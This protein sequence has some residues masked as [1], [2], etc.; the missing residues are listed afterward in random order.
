MRVTA[1][2]HAG[3]RVETEQATVLCDPWFSPEGA[4]QASWHQ[5]PSNDHL[6]SDPT[7]V[8]P[9]AIAISHE[10]LDHVDPWFLAR[11]PSGVPV[12]V[13]RYPSPA[14]RRKI[15]MGGP[16]SIIELEQW[17]T[18]E[19]AS[20][21][22]IFFVS[23][24]PMNHDSAIIVQGDGHTLLDLND[25]RLFPV[26]LREIREKVGGSVEIFSFQG[27]GASW[28]PMCYRYPG[29]QARKLSASKR[30][31]KLAYCF[32]TMRVLDPVV[33]LP[34]AGPPAFLDPELMEQNAEMEEGIFPDQEQVA[35]WLNK[36]NIKNTVVLLPG[37]TWDTVGRTKEEHPRSSAFTFQDRWPYLHEYAERRKPHVESV[38][39]RH[40]NPTESLWPQFRE[41]FGE[42][43]SM[44]PYF[45]ERIGMRV[46][47]TIEGPG[48]GDWSVDFR[49]GS[50]AVLKEGN[51]C[52]YGY[53]FAS[54]WLPSILEGKVPWEDFFLSLRFEAWRQPDLYND[55]LLGLLKFAEPEALAAVESFETG[56]ASDER[57]TIHSEGRVYS[58][59]R[60][61][62]HAGNDLLNTGEVLPGGILRCLA[63]HYE[64]DLET[65]RCLNGSCSPLAVEETITS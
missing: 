22:S 21:T 3:L 37:D 28:Y 7:L 36:R 54:R 60:F 26:Q 29:E 41:Y 5:Y 32:R 61:C 58:V 2:G 27:A 48:G 16:R 39:K 50:E 65:G 12:I 64:F 46:G 47:F 14:L 52:A 19:I 35:A 20:G 44:S 24:P 55:H 18:F 4:F 17:E 53:R 33:G 34:F 49:P 1:L 59:S 13:P 10:H 23:E 25:A 30:M 8:R 11:V 56:L 15:E 40:P 43:L 9:T 51:G 31:T 38:L 62:P 63:H 57:F 6:L 42:L 45:N